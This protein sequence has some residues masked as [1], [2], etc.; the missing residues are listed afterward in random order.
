MESYMRKSITVRMRRGSNQN[1]TKIPDDDHEKVKYNV[2]NRV[3]YF[4]INHY[5]NILFYINLFF[6]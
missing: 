6:I 1:T 3:L 2:K 4:K 5:T